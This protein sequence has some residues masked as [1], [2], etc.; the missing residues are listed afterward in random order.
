VKALLLAPLAAVLALAQWTAS[1]NPTPGPDYALAACLFGNYVAVVGYS[2]LPQQSPV[3]A[4]LDRETG[5]AAG[6]LRGESGYFA[7]CASMGDVLYAAGAGIYAFDKNL[8]LV[9]AAGGGFYNSL[10][11]HGGLLYAVGFAQRGDVGGEVWLIEVRGRD[12]NLTDALQFHIGGWKSGRALDAAVNPATGQL[13][14]VGYYVDV[15]GVMHSLLAIFGEGLVPVKYVDYPWWQSNYT[16]ALNGIC[17]DEEGNAYVAG[18]LGVAKFDKNGNLVKH[19]REV[20]AVKIACQRSRVYAFGI[21]SGNYVRR[22]IAV[23]SKDLEV[24]AVYTL[25]GENGTLHWFLPGKPAVGEK[26]IYAAGYDEDPRGS[27]YKWKI[28][29]VPTLWVIQVVDQQGR[30]IPGLLVKAGKGPH[31]PANTTNDGGIAVFEGVLQVDAFYIYQNSVLVA[32][33]PPVQEAVVELPRQL[34]V[35]NAVAARGILVVKGV[36]F[37]NGSRED[38]AYFF[39]VRDGA[40]EVG[41]VLPV[42]HPAELRLTHVAVGNV[43]V[44]VSYAAE[45]ASLGAG[46]DFAQLGIVANLTVQAADGRGTQ[47][48]DWAIEILYQDAAVAKANATLTATLPRTTLLGGPYLVKITT[49]AKTH[50]GEPFTAAKPLNL[51]Q[52]TTIQVQIPTIKL[53][54]VAID[55]FGKRRDW[56]VEV[57]NVATG[58]GTTTAEVVEGAKYTAKAA[59]LG[60]VNVT[61]FVARG[62]EMVVAVKIPTGWVAARVVDGFGRARDWPVEVVGVAAGRGAVGVEVLPGRYTVKATAFG[63]EYTQTVEVQPGQNQTITIQVPTAMLNIVVLDDD[64]R[65][66]D[67]YVTAV[68]IIGPLTADLLTPPKGLEVP[69]GEYTIRVTALGRESPPVTV[70]V[71]PGEEKTVEVVV[72]GTAGIDARGEWPILA[73]VQ[74]AVV[75]WAL[76]TAVILLVVRRATRPS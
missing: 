14:V 69:P 31:A 40:L 23:L 33:V 62:P 52:D 72:P 65:L 12:L 11:P 42:G 67:R 55:G 47:R 5:S 35:A 63:R 43:E 22:H 64:R 49:T 3:V 30:P 41:G 60:F 74:Y 32:T 24:V 21:H 58:I 50:T 70:E 73:I 27:D 68:V 56:P 9:K 20:P 6:W 36:E 18:S 37:L 34:P 28:Y 44:A 53:T 29:A 46:I 16:G 54:V 8:T 48:P 19:S 39:Q 66:I 10:V 13:W 1:F 17:F 26:T 38:V 61:E 15:Q 45:L 7:A 59:G 75:F 2:D 4:L 57:V 25:P 76:I 51:T 71:G